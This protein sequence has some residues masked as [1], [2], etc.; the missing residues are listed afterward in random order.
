MKERS[1]RDEERRLNKS[2]IVIAKSPKAPFS[3]KGGIFYARTFATENYTDATYKTHK[4][5]QNYVHKDLHDE[6]ALMIV[7]KLLLVVRCVRGRV[8]DRNF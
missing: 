4:K 1:R 8:F 5:R 3:K 6:F 2:Q 7:S